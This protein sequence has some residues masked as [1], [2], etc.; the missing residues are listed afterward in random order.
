MSEWRIESNIPPETRAERRERI[1]VQMMGAIAGREG[2]TSWASQAHDAVA[3]A[4][5]LLNELDKAA[6]KDKEE[7]K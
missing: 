5:A 7:T 1:A 6:A 2:Y 3:M 4:D